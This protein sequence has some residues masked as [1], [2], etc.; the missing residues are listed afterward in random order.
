[1]SSRFYKSICRYFLRGG[2]VMI[3]NLLARFWAVGRGGFYGAISCMGFLLL[4]GATTGTAAAQDSAQFCGRNHGSAF[5]C[6]RD[7][8]CFYSDEARKC[9]AR[10]LDCSARRF[11]Q[12]DCRRTAGC[13]WD[14]RWGD[15][16]ED[17]RI[18]HGGGGGGNQCRWLSDD[19]RQCNRTPGCEYDNWTNRC[20]RVGGGGGG[21]PGHGSR[22]VIPCSSHQSAMQTCHVAGTVVSARLIRN[23]G[24]VRC[25]EGSNWGRSPRGIWVRGGCS[26]QF[27][28][29]VRRL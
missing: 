23:T 25:Y 22:V 19:P 9:V 15:C 8:R 17:P 18:G 12:W 27:E 13:L 24:M 14:H 29:I 2:N 20:E 3:Q 1:M 16:V 11:D 10:D 7:S 4:L 21:H 28:L 6:E 5:I 26:G